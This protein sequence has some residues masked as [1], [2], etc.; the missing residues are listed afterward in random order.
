MVEFSGKRTFELEPWSL[1]P[2][3]QGNV[4][5]TFISIFLIYIYDV[6]VYI[7]MY[8]CMYAC[9]HACMSV[10]LSVYVCMHACMHAWMDGWMDVCMYR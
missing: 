9:M 8:V 5:Y 4:Y 10:C 7:C 3:K 6:F 1:E 2:E